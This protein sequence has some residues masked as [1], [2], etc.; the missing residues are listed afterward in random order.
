MD[1]GKSLLS[2][3]YRLPDPSRRSPFIWGSAPQAYFARS[4]RPQS[5][6]PAEAP[7]PP[8]GPAPPTWRRVGSH[9]SASTVTMARCP[10]AISCSSHCTTVHCAESQLWVGAGGLHHQSPAPSD[11]PPPSPKDPWRVRGR[12]VWSPPEEGS[13]IQATEHQGD[14]GKK[15]VFII[16][17]FT[18]Q[19]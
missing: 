8:G 12:D 13:Q 18:A 4:S 7:P 14:G 2:A 11:L 16:M 15:G 3:V 19:L 9:R 6:P 10:R 5:C 1:E 17:V